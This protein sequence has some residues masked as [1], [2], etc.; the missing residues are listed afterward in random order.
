MGQSILVVGEMD[1]AGARHLIIRRPDGSA[2]YLPGWMAAPVAASIEMMACPR[3]PMHRLIELRAFL[4]QFKLGP[5]RVESLVVAGTPQM[6]M[7]ES[8]AEHRP[9]LPDLVMLGTRGR[10]GAATVAA[11]RRC[12]SKSLA[13]GLINTIL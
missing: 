8:L 13:L 7:S 1:H 3:L 6:A 12:G 2:F 11:R 5:L 4:H 9:D 10:S